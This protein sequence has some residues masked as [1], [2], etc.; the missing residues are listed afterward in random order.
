MARFYFHLWR[1]GQ[2][3]PDEVGVALSSLKAAKIRAERIASSIL[4]RNEAAPTRWFGWDIQV[5]DVAGM[6]TRPVSHAAI[7]EGDR[8]RR[9]DGKAGSDHPCLVG[10]CSGHSPWLI[11]TTS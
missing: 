3:T 11:S 5:T 6:H 2:L 8:I 10:A 7:G 9:I 1:L 4:D